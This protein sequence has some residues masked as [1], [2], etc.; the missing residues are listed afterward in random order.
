MCK[1][2]ADDVVAAVQRL[3]KDNSNVK[4]IRVNVREDKKSAYTSV[5]FEYAE[6]NRHQGTD[7]GLC[8][9]LLVIAILLFLAVFQIPGCLWKKVERE[10][11]AVTI[12]NRCSN[13]M[14]NMTLQMRKTKT[15]H[16][17]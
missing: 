11:T 4:A 2:L 16:K 5:E 13:A 14:L 8:V 15:L 10:N 9:S 3:I 1:M 12:T 17:E 6:S 7:W